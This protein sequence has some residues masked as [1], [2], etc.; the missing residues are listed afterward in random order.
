MDSIKN[1]NPTFLLLPSI[2]IVNDA[3]GSIANYVPRVKEKSVDIGHAVFWND[4]KVQQVIKEYG[5]K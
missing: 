3:C 5:V 2:R 4:E 1:T